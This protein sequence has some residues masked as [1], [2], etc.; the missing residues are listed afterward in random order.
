M[1][2]HDEIIIFGLRSGT[3]NTLVHIDV[4]E[5]GRDCNCECPYCHAPLV[6]RNAGKGGRYRQNVHHFAHDK[7]YEPCGK[8]RM[9]ALHIMAQKILEQ[10]KQVMLPEYVKKYVQH[11]AKPQSFDSV[12]LEELCRDEN[13]TRRPDCIGKPYNDGSLWIEIYCTNPIHP[14]REQDIIRKKQY[15]I[16]IDLSDLLNTEYTEETLKTR[17]LTGSKDRKWICH[18][19]W[20]E[21][22]R[23]KEEEAKC[24]EDKIRSQQE[25]KR[26]KIAEESRRRYEEIER[27]KEAE[28]LRKQEEKQRRLV[29]SLQEQP[30]VTS[31]EFS[32]SSHIDDSKPQNIGERDWIMYAKDIY[33]RKDALTSFF[34]VLRAE[35]EKVSLKNSHPFVVEELHM[36]INAL[37]TRMDI[38]ADVNKTYLALLIAIWVLDKLNS[39]KASNLGKLFVEDKSIRN[40]VY[41]AVKQMRGNTPRTIEDTLVPM[42]TENRDVILQILRICYTN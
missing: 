28:S 21:E 37:I 10:E 19:E 32:P 3:T 31:T 14:D 12:T 23:I 24:K 33:S 9:S 41:N 36:K 42:E 18:P 5:N 34:A 25:I 15:C 20:D 39:N 29:E 1:N 17:L 30:R 16:E 8:G 2:A 40:S 7:G 11:V 6:A 4:A 26:R 13:S 35:Y 38:I 22:E 27:E